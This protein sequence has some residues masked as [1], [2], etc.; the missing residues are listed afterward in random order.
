MLRKLFQNLLALQGC[1][2][3][4]LRNGFASYKIE[5]LQLPSGVLGRTPAL[6]Q[7]ERGLMI[8]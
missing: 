5:L 2:V 3:C 6:G 7:K 8:L 1:P 4:A